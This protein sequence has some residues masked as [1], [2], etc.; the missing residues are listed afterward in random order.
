M[1][2]VI[3]CD[4]DALNALFVCIGNISDLLAD[5]DFNLFR[6]IGGSAPIIDARISLQ[7]ASTQLDKAC[8]TAAQSLG[9]TIECKQ[10]R[11]SKSIQ[12]LLH[13]AKLIQSAEKL[14]AENINA[15]YEPCEGCY[16]WEQVSNKT[17]HSELSHAGISLDD[18]V[19][20][21]RRAVNALR[22]DGQW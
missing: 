4:N 2:N 8:K 7:E 16:V 1:L 13:A 5:I 17:G 21:L 11:P 22:G 6:Y 15:P 19:Y 18:A 9:V 14:I 10:Y 12:S 3:N 20:A